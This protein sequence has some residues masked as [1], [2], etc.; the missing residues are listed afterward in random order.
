MSLCSPKL[1]APGYHRSCD[2]TGNVNLACD[3]DRLC[4]GNPGRRRLPL[5]GVEAS[6][7]LKQALAPMAGVRASLVR[8][9]TE[10]SPILSPLSGF[11]RRARTVLSRPEA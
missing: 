1:D 5:N 10:R 3:S 4:N 11:P 9:P 8:R 6:V 2:K 7:L